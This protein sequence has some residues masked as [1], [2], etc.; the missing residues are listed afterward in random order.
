ML[1]FSDDALAGTVAPATRTTD[2]AAMRRSKVEVTI[3]ASSDVLIEDR[4][5][6]GP[7]HSSTPGEAEHEMNWVTPAGK[8]MC[9]GLDGCCDSFHIRFRACPA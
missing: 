6:R 7:S 5:E 8:N 4:P 1:N 9:G 3:V 2:V